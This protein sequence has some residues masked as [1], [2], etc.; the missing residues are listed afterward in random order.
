MAGLFVLVDADLG[1]VNA[2]SFRF[3]GFVIVQKIRAIRSLIH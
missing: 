2:G 3:D 1:G